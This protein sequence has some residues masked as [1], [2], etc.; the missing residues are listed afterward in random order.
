[1]ATR[2]K[3]VGRGEADRKERTAFVRRELEKKGY[4]F[5]RDPAKRSKAERKLRAE[6]RAKFY[7]S[8]N[9]DSSS[10]KEPSPKTA[11]VRDAGAAGR[12]RSNMR[13]RDAG[14]RGARPLSS[15]NMR[16][17]D[18]G[19]AGRPQPKAVVRDAGDRT[20]RKA[21]SKNMA[22]RD[23]ARPRPKAVVRDSGD[24]ASR[25]LTSKNVVTRDAARP[26]PKMRTR[27]AGPAGARNYRNRY[28]AARF[29]RGK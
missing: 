15:R 3:G 4:A 29:R 5:T 22:I 14:D 24:R 20:P 12:P 9:K 13:I 26:R 28:D 18:A 11:T 10:R 21:S 6:A 19:A 7:G 25:K 17:R 8:T 2:K 23:A 1:M 27:D 16:V